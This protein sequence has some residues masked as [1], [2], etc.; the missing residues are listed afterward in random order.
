LFPPLP[1]HPDPEESS[2]DL[3]LPPHSPSVVV[4]PNPL[5]QNWKLDIGKYIEIP[6][7]NI[8][9]RVYPSETPVTDRDAARQ[10]FWEEVEALSANSLYGG[11]RIL[12]LVSISVRI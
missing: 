7:K 1:L 12:I 2:F 9:V 11:A 10:L 8:V 6:R 5:V 3:A 4:L